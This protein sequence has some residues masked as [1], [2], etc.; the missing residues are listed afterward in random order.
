MG[1]RDM[2]NEMERLN[3]Q[4]AHL[5]K[6][7]KAGI[8]KRSE[9]LKGKKKVDKKIKH[10]EDKVQD[11]ETKT[12]AVKKIIE[13]PK[14]KKNKIAV[15]NTNK[16]TEPKDKRST[17]NDDEKSSIWSYL[18]L[19]LVIVMVLFFVYKYT[20]TLAP[21]TDSVTI[22]DYSNFFCDHCSDLQE[23]LKEIK[24]DYGVKVKIYHRQFPNNKIHPLSTMAA[25]ASECANDQGRFIEYHNLLF[26][27]NNQI[28]DAEDFVDLARDVEIEQINKFEN[29]LN[30]HEKLEEVMDDV[31]EGKESGV[32]AIPT[33]VIDG[34][35]L[36]GAQ[37]YKVISSV[38]N[39]H[40]N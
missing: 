26:M 32:K 6:S 14:S 39:K 13:K 3:K 24:K 18:L 36:K 23:T 35:V 10:L 8:V 7:Y 16:I 22:Y 29:C 27:G 17:N 34:E 11:Q 4:L 30:N 31:K 25:E 19:L 15:I 21:T 1:C 5:E 38:I 20:E 28:D 37:S 9:Y 40:L 33:L 12:A 2:E